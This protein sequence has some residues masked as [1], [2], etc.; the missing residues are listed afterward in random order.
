MHHWGIGSCPPI[1]DPASECS[2]L[3]VGSTG[4]STDLPS[5]LPNGPLTDSSAATVLVRTPQPVSQRPPYPPYPLERLRPSPT[6]FALSLCK[7]FQVPPGRVP[8]PRES[9]TSFVYAGRRM[10]GWRAT[11]LVRY[12]C[13]PTQILRCA[14]QQCRSWG[15]AR[16]E[17]RFFHWQFDRIGSSALGLCKLV[18]LGLRADKTESS[19]QSSPS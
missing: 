13:T 2:K 11:G 12:T 18:D 4:D 9:C 17:W 7:V 15:L 5:A 1:A 3:H 19:I 16:R 14:N 10:V 6:S 8:N